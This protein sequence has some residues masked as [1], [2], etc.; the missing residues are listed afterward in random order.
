[1]SSDVFARVSPWGI[2]PFLQVSALTLY[3]VALGFSISGM[4][5][6]SVLLLVL[7]LWQKITEPNSIIWSRPPLLWPCLCFLAVALI[8]VWLGNATTEQKTYDVKRMRFFILYAILFWLLLSTL[9]TFKWDRVFIAIALFMGV[10]GTIQHFIPLDIFRATGKKIILFAI[11]D[12][13]IGPLVIGSFNH[14]LTF[15]GVYLFYACVLTAIG[16]YSRKRLHLFCGLWLFLLVLFTQSR[17]AWVAVPVSIMVLLSWKGRQFVLGALCGC[18]LILGSLYFADTGFR[19]RAQ[20]TLIGQ[21]EI[22]STS[23]RLRLWNAQLAM[24]RDH[25]WFGVGW[26]N[27]ER[28][29]REYLDKLYPNVAEV[30]SGHAHSNFLQILSSTGILGTL[31]YLWIWITVFVLTWQLIH[32]FPTGSL[33]RS[34]GMGLFAAFIGFHIQGLTQWNFGDAEVLHNVIF[35]W[36]LVSALVTLRRD[37]SASPSYN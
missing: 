25:P 35:F 10:Y 34:T 12:E 15:S 18:A 13:R 14:H 30:F 5:G 3:I 16:V 21:E 26:N 36:A 28:R 4:E 7:L 17:V 37:R 22:Y 29:S 33:E 20:R 23:P 1:M 9:K 27:S 19:E 31:G 24:F 2:R 8:G 11:Q 6:V 32:L